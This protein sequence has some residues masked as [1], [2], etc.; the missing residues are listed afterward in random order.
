MTKSLQAHFLSLQRDLLN[1]GVFTMKEWGKD[2][3]NGAKRGS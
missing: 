1:R 3:E 2:V